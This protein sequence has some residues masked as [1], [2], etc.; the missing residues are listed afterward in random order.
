VANCSNA[1]FAAEIERI[2][3]QSVSGTNMNFVVLVHVRAASKAKVYLKL[4]KP[5]EAKSA[6]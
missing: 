5:A 6:R 3:N 1:L 4:A 2:S